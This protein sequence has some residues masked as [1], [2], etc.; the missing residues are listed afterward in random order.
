M[1]EAIEFPLNFERFMEIGHAAF[2]AEEFSKAE[3]N[4]TSAYDLKADFEANFS[5]V[6]SLIAQS[7]LNE[8]L[9]IAMEMRVDYLAQVETLKIFLR[10]LIGTGKYIPAHKLVN[11]LS[12]EQ[13]ALVSE[14]V[15]S[16]EMFKHYQQQE[17][18][19]L[20]QLKTELCKSTFIDQASILKEWDHLPLVDYLEVAYSVIEVGELPLILRNSLLA[21]LVELGSQKPLTISLLDGNKKIVIP[22]DLPL[23]EAQ[24]SARQ[25]QLILVELIENPDS[26]LYRQLKEELR[27][28]FLLLYP[29]ADSLITNPRVWVEAF[30]A[31]YLGTE[32]TIDSEFESL[33]KDY[34]ALFE[35]I[36]RV[37]SEMF[38]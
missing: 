7:K 2:H 9:K 10:L 23:I 26:D 22:A 16:E 30:L 8:A 1:G 38:M 13:S 14:I 36:S 3:Q 24:E 35:Q 25:A 34:G 31:N 28:H 19:R 29:I 15:Q 27:L 37:L 21:E 20:K 12:I 18:R 4:F 33:K 17:L 11:K 32:N 5:L 6:E